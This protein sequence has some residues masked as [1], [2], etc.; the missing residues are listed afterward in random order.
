MAI[1]YSNLTVGL[2]KQN[3][4][5]TIE[6]PQG[7]SG[8]GLDIFV[9]DDVIV[10]D[11]AINDSTLSADLWCTKPSG[12]MVSVGATT[13]SKFENSNAYEIQFSDTLTFQNILA[14]EGIVN[15]QVTLNS[16]NT[17]VT[18]FKF[19][20]KVVNNIAMAEKIESTDEYKNI[21]ELITTTNKYINE[22]KDY[23]DKFEKQLKLTVNVRSGTSDP[24]VLSTDSAGDLYIKYEE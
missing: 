13:V 19:K 8:R 17:Y 18:S 1:V 21:L 3:A 9:S 20:I 10:D 6:M 4:I 11:Q 2:T 22:L 5:L 23:V 7:D 14:E 24:E 12:L 16:S 15:A